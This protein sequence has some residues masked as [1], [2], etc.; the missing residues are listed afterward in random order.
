MADIV[1][2]YARE[3]AE[4]AFEL[5]TLIEQLGLTVWWDR[6]L[7]AGENFYV[8]IDAEIAKA[9]RVI[10]LWSAHSV[11]SDWVLSE[12]QEASQQQK[13]LPIRIGDIKIPLGFRTL[14]SL[15]LNDAR[16]RMREVLTSVKLLAPIAPASTAPIASPPAPAAAPVAGAAPSVIPP[17][18]LCDRLAADR[19]DVTRVADGIGWPDLDVAKAVI[20]CTAAV[21]QFPGTARFEYQLARAHLVNKDDVAAL[22]WLEAAAGRGHAIAMLCLGNLYVYGEF[23]PGR[24]QRIPVDVQKGLACWKRAAAA[25]STVAM[26]NLALVLQ[27]GEL[28]PRDDSAALRWLLTAW[29]AGSADAAASIGDYH[30]N[31]HGT[32]ADH[33]EALAWY[34][35][36]LA[37]GEIV[38]ASRSGPAFNGGF[39]RPVDRA[40]D[41]GFLRLLAEYGNTDAKD[42]L[43]KLMDQG[44]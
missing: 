2:S 11:S 35:K 31:G 8:A 27:E 16:A 17:C 15:E 38:F 14:H 12:A 10:V 43:A 13:L 7:V 34:R 23:T 1:I 25:G 24:G 22:P 6:R 9:Q 33:N 41:I 21:E 19:D 30:A 3:D 18:L 26:S 4:V 42:S 29:E 39:G 20:A 40:F 37:G 44:V 36:A 5:A 28:V 32:P